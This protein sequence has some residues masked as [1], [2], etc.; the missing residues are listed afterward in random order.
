MKIL[1]KIDKEEIYFYIRKEFYGKLTA[2]IIV[3]DEK[4]KAFPLKSGIRDDSVSKKNT[5]KKWAEDL[6][7]L[8]FSEEDIQMISR[9][10]KRCSTS[11]VIMKM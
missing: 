7:W 9:H 2:N 4:L 5:I 1:I 10:M 6:D 11:I 8:A 3:N